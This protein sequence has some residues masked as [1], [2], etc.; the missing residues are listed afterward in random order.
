MATKGRINQ[1][2]AVDLFGNPLTI[3]I[4]EET[5]RRALDELFRLTHRY[6]STKDYDELLKFMRRFGFYAPYNAMLIHVQ[7]PGAKFVA[8]PCEPIDGLRQHATP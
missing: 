1:D 2:A 7:M 6:S 5:T 8:P 4:N 3:P